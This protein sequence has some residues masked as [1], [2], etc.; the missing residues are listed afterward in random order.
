VQF[1]HVAWP[2][3]AN[4]P[5]TQ[6]VLSWPSLRDLPAAQSKQNEAPALEVFPGAHAVQSVELA[7]EKVP[8]AQSEQS[9]PPAPAAHAS[10]RLPMKV[11]AHSQEA[12]PS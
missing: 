10:H 5:G 4:V 2:A 6:A 1:V 3:P 9:W 7:L 8:A 12:F 11:L